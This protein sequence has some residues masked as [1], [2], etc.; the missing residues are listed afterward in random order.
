MV[1]PGAFQGSRK[2]FLQ[3]QKAA[4]SA[5]VVGGYAADALSII[6]RHYF[7][8]FPIDLPDDDE[9]D[10]EVL[11]SIDDDTPDIE[12]EEPD[13]VLLVPEEYAAAMSALE[14]RRSAITFRKAVSLA[15]RLSC[16]SCQVTSVYSTAN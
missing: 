10:P 13:E 3:S 11:A 1:N 12:Q 15:T 5:G 8:R 6:Q 9:P 7:K 16:S 4:Y 2:A 14:A